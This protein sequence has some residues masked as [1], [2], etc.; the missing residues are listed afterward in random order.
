MKKEKRR[1]LAGDD[2]IVEVYDGRMR[3]S[4]RGSYVSLPWDAE[5]KADM[6][7]M[8]IER[9]EDGSAAVIVQSLIPWDTPDDTLDTLM[10]TTLNSIEE[11]L[12]VPSESLTSAAWAAGYGPCD[13]DELLTGEERHT[14]LYA[15]TSAEES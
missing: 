7:R 4:V 13:S 5:L 1:I 15:E 14:L 11:I 6:H 9:Y 8:L 12:G 10:E 3:F 2:C